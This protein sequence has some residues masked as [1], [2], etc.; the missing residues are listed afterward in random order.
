MMRGQTLIGS[1]VETLRL[2]NERL[3]S[4]V[5]TKGPFTRAQGY[6]EKNIE[7]EYRSTHST[8]EFIPTSIST[9]STKPITSENLQIDDI[10]SE[11]T[12]ALAERDA[13][14]SLLK[15]SDS[16]RQVSNFANLANH[17]KRMRM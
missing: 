15:S 10:H 16:R 17:P 8:D 4:L 13:L 5:Q 3:K 7:S 12:R 2:E 9:S 1:D 14:A 6:Q 11:L